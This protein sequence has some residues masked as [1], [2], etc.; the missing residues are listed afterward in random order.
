MIRVLIFTRIKMIRVLIFTRLK[1]IRVLI[2]SS[3]NDTSS[4]FYS[5]QNDT[6]SNF[7]RL[8]MIRV[9]IL[10]L[11][12]DMTLFINKVQRSRIL[13]FKGVINKVLV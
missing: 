6:S 13:S 12:S 9:L 2:Y 1:L 5:S 7:I 10:L 8:K 4:N 11:S 3:Q